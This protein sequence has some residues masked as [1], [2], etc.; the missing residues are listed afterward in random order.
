MS[1]W[2]FTTEKRY[3][4]KIAAPNGRSERKLQTFSELQVSWY[5]I[6]SSFFL[7]ICNVTTLI[8]ALFWLIALHKNRNWKWNRKLYIVSR[9]ILVPI[10]AKCLS[11]ET[12]FDRVCLN[13]F[14]FISFI[15]ALLPS[16]GL[17][18]FGANI[19]NIAMSEGLCGSSM[20][21]SDR[22][23]VGVTPMTAGK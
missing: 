16:H 5:F 22:W 9:W 21:G 20:F 17:P 15:G 18:P 2:W 19:T 3:G 14:F 23:S 12:Q 11:N 4:F 8:S 1:P 6:R 7:E 13:I 10:A